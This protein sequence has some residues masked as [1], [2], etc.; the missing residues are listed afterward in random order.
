MFGVDTLKSYAEMTCDSLTPDFLSYI[1]VRT[2]DFL[3]VTTSRK[4]KSSKR[5]RRGGAF[6]L[7]PCLAKSSRYPP[8]TWARVCLAAPGELPLARPRGAAGRS[9]SGR[10]ADEQRH[11]LG[12]VARRRGARRVVRPRVADA[13][14]CDAPHTRVFSGSVSQRRTVKSP[15]PDI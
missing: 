9:C 6:V 7:S 12:R 10:P 2:Y 4:S 15:E 3:V 14:P 1:S 13:R 5:L 8:Q 11:R